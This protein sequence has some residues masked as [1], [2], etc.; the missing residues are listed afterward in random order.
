[1]LESFGFGE[2]ICD[3]GNTR[4]LTVDETKRAIRRFA[5]HVMPAFR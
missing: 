2:L 1:M 4:Q 3:F 5:E